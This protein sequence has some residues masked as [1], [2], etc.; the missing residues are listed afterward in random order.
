[1][2]KQETLVSVVS[3]VR[4]WLKVSAAD[5]HPLAAARFSEEPGMIRIFNP[6]PS[7]VACDIHGQLKPAPYPQLVERSLRVIFDYLLCRAGH[8][9]N[10]TVRKPLPGQINDRDFLRS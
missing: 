6:V 2:W 4:P 10:F 5:Q 9:A 7:S 8:F 1:M 3:C